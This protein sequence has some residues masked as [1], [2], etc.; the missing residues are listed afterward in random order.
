MTFG[1]GQ[2]EGVESIGGGTLVALI[3][4]LVEVSPEPSIEAVVGSMDNSVV[5]ELFG[6]GGHL[7]G[8]WTSLHNSELQ[9]NTPCLFLSSGL[10]GDSAEEQ[11]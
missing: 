2:F 6:E 7:V 4:T 11:P 9:Q 1:G 10:H 8:A 5:A 3:M